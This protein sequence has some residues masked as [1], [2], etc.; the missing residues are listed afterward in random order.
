ML[1]RALTALSVV[2]MTLVLAACGGD[3]SS[4]G[5]DYANSVCGELSEWVTSVDEAAQSIQDAG[6][7]ATTET[8]RA[9][10]SDVSDATGELVDDLEAI[11]A[12]ETD[13]GNEAKSALDSLGTELQKQVDTVEQALDDGGGLAAQL[14][15]ITAA[16][17]AAAADVESTFNQLR[18]LDPAGELREGFENADECD[19]LSEQASN[20]GS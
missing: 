2:A 14:S 9:A 8:L 7:S 16:I 19:S 1:V 4:T 20:F 10:V 13:D 11:G 6:L 15:A 3:D 18:E 12:P 5:E 17:S